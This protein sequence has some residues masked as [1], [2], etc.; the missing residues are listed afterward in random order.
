MFRQHDIAP[1]KVVEADNELVIASLVV[2]GMGMGLMREEIALEKARAHAI[3]LWNDVRLITTLQFIYLEERKDDAPMRAL[4]DV[5]HEIWSSS[6]SSSPVKQP[7][8]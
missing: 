4:I 7:S 3:C 5:L 2:A 8:G 1:S 6:D